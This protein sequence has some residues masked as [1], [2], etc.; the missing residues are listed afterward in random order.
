M[1]LM[2]PSIFNTCIPR[3]EILY[4]ELSL[5]LFAA[6]LRL[7]VERSAPQDYQDPGIFNAF[8]FPTDGLKMLIVDD[9]FDAISPFRFNQE[10]L[11]MFAKVAAT[12]CTTRD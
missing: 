12:Q 3:A 9:L 11:Q 2:L 10:A 5:D 1:T 6:K 4:E 7:V 8:T